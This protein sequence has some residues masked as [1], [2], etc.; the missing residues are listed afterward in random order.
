M[1]NRYYRPSMVASLPF[2][3][4]RKNLAAALHTTP[5]AQQWLKSPVSPPSPINRNLRSIR[6]WRR[7]DSHYCFITKIRDDLRCDHLHALTVII[8]EIVIDQEFQHNLV[9]AP[10]AR[11]GGERR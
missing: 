11:N 5:L 4:R 6:W 3:G 10:A 9:A 2:A 1:S 7:E 8:A